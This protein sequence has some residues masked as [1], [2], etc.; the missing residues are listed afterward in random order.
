KT[1]SELVELIL[2]I[3]DIQECG[4]TLKWTGPVVAITDC[5][6]IQTKLT[7]SQELGC[8]VG[9]TLGFDINIT[10]YDDIHLKIKEI[11]DNNLI[12]S[13]V[14]SS[15]YS[16]RPIIHVQDSKHAKKNRRNAIHSEARLLVLG[17]NT[18]RYD[19]LYQLAYKENSALYIRD[20]INID[21]QDD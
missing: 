10:I 13:Q 11:Q 17:N 15:I 21:K 6:K 16:K 20:V 8:I 5:T 2:Q 12:A 3:K 4:K 14:R 19:Q 18:I 7:Y 9:S 1:F